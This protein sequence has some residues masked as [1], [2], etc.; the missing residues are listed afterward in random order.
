MSFNCPTLKN[1][2]TS[3]KSDK[4]KLYVK[5]GFQW[6]YYHSKHFSCHILLTMQ[7]RNPLQY[8]FR[9]IALQELDFYRNSLKHYITRREANILTGLCPGKRS[10][11][12]HR[13]L[14][15]SS[16]LSVQDIS[17]THRCSL[18]TLKEQGRF[19]SSRSSLFSG[20]YLLPSAPAS[21]LQHNPALQ[22]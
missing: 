11:K 9:I 15:S 14:K 19:P 7:A 20:H 10:A 6:L 18:E 3:P 2:W 21:V 1:P 4:S 5:S 13:C 17:P 16:E 8:S 22:Q 12:V